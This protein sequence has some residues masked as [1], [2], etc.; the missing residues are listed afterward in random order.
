MTEH[1]DSERIRNLLADAMPGPTAAAVANSRSN[2]ESWYQG[3]APVTYWC[4]LGTPIGP[5]HLAASDVGLRRISFTGNTSAF[6]DE[7]DGRSRLIE[8]PRAM[9]PYRQQLLDY[10]NGGLRR[11]SLPLDLTTVT[12]FQRRVLSAIAK[13]PAGTVRS[14]GQVAA[15]IGKPKAA[16]AVGQALGSNPIPI[17]LPCHRV[18]ASDGS[19]GGYAGGLHRKRQLLALEGDG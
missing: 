1:P 5:L 18:V 17:V 11:F 9:A 14:Y 2:V 6:L 19:L 7:L 10:F 8:D 16:R 13:I 15:A 3:I 4:R 12:A